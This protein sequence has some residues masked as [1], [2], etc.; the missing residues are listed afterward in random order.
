MLILVID[1]VGYSGSGKTFFITSTIKLLSTKLNYNISVIKNVKH[2]P[3]D[4]EGK[5]SYRYNEAG[6]NFSI[7][8]NINNETAIFTKIKEVN[9]KILL[10]WLNSG[11][12]KSDLTFTEGFRNLNNPTVLCV[13]DL[14]E[15][16]VQLTE[17]IKMISGIICSKKLI[18]KKV[19]NIPIIDVKNQFSEFL[20]LFDIF[21]EGS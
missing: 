1:V 2:H 6:A 7:I 14:N 19:N 15:I 11:P 21:P 12:F 8:Q 9:L 17:N 20:K 5:D 3:I 10:K 13:S 16:E 4:E 18:K